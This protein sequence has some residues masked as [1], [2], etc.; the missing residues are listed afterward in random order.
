[1]SSGNIVVQQ[2]IKLLRIRDKK[3]DDVARHP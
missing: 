2:L 3:K 1:M